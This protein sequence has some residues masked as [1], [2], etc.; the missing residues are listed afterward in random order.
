MAIKK[1]RG[2]PSVGQL[3]IGYGLVYFLMGVNIVLFGISTYLTFKGINGNNTSA[4]Y[5]TFMSYAMAA[6]V[7]GIY[8]FRSIWSIFADDTKYKLGAFRFHRY[9]LL[10]WLVWGVFF[11]VSFTSNT[12]QLANIL[13]TKGFYETELVQKQAALLRTSAA[14]RG[15]EQNTDSEEVR[16]LRREF[17]VLVTNLRIQVLDPNRPGFGKRAKDIQKELLTDKFVGPITETKFNEALC[18]SKNTLDKCSAELERMISD[19]TKQFEKRTIAPLTV[20]SDQLRDKIKGYLVANDK[21]NVEVTDL[22]QNKD[23]SIVAQETN[24][25]P[26]ES[27]QSFV[28]SQYEKALVDEIGHVVRQVNSQIDALRIDGQD[29]GLDKLVFE[30]GGFGDFLFF[31]QKSWGL[32]GTDDPV[33]KQ[34]LNRIYGYFFIGLLIDLLPFGLS[35][36]AA[37]IRRAFLGTAEARAK[38]RAQNNQEVVQV[39][40]QYAPVT[41]PSYP[42]SPSSPSSPSRLGKKLPPVDAQPTNKPRPF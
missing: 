25:N 32:F 39:Q 14:L 16:K 15:K 19:Y 5:W 27:H 30:N 3:L 1:K 41:T 23:T 36:A 29:L 42:T 4:G 12:S 21:L 22:L 17:D 28:A 33:L 8:L 38:L 2:G 40:P 20:N 9:N 6:G 10:I 24:Y 37:I 13:G 18:K 26:E 35:A 34:E 31:I 7:F 11:A